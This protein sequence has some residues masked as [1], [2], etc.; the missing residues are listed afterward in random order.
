MLIIHKIKSLHQSLKRACN[1]SGFKKM[2]LILRYIPIIVI[3]LFSIYVKIIK[4]DKEDI[5]DS[6]LYTSL[7][8]IWL[9]IL[10][11][12]AYLNIREYILLKRIASFF[13]LFLGMLFIAGF[14]FTD[15]LLKLRDKSPI[16]I[17][18]GYDGGFNG[19]WFEFRE[20]GTYKFGNSGGLGADYM[21]GKYSIKDSIIIL[22]KPNI[23]NTIIT[24]NRLVIRKNKKGKN[25]IYQINALNN[26]I[27]RE[28]IFNINED[29][30]K[31]I[32]AH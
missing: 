6:I 20:D 16:L 28:F 4:A 30:R 7:S 25:S 17:Q 11:I 18:A 10:W 32:T 24:T 29:N 15:Y 9:L 12:T 2:Y 26:P 23:E 14:Y 19:C 21:R 22:D 27:N 31:K 3:G 1:M 5:F 8:V 13:P